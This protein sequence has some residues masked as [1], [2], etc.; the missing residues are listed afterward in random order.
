MIQQHE[1][2]L[3]WGAAI[4]AVSR[5]AIDMI[6]QYS[7][8]GLCIATETLPLRNDITDVRMISFDS[9]LLPG[10]IGVTVIYSGSHLIVVV[11]FQAGW[12]LKLNTIIC[13]NERKELPENRKSQGL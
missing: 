4:E 1:R 9:S 8:I 6:H 13:E 2:Q 10:T 7:C 5:F 3:K 11:T 12:E